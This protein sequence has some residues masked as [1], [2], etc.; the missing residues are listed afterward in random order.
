ML[1]FLNQEQKKSL[2]SFFTGI[3]VGW[4]IALFASPNFLSDIKPLTIVSYLVNII[5]A[6]FLSLFVLKEEKNND[7]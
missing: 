6:I 5:G 4:F 7:E 3:S 1:R 2:S